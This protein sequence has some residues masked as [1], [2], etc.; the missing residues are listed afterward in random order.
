MRQNTSIF[1][2][3]VFLVPALGIAQVNGEGLEGDKERVSYS[4]GFQMGEKLV[5]GK[6]RIDLDSLLRGLK[7]RLNDI[8]PLLSNDVMDAITGEFETTLASNRRDM[9]IEAELKFLQ[10][11][12]QLEGVF[13]LASGLQYKV[14]T[15]GNGKSPVATDTVRAHYEGRLLTGEIFDSSYERGTPVTLPVDGVIPG[16]SEAL[17]LMKEGDKWQLYVPYAMAYGERGAPPRIA[18]FATLIFEI[19][20]IKIYTEEERMEIESHGHAH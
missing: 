1:T 11:N 14:L 3:L 16:W 19:E 15:S 20:L 8:D 4:V 9:K 18:P 12:A 13:Q 2:F 6:D 5:Y 10:A 17:Q 7:H